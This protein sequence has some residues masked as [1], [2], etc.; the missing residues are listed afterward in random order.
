[1]KLDEEALCVSVKA[2]LAHLIGMHFDE[3]VVTAFL[4]HRKLKR[5]QLSGERSRSCRVRGP[6]QRKRREELVGDLEDIDRSHLTTKKMPHVP[7]LP[8][9]E[10]TTV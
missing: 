8:S 6:V 1:M 5:S 4:L 10:L 9:G 3:R 7:Y 2:A